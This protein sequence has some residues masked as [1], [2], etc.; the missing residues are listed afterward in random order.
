MSAWSGVIE[1]GLDQFAIGKHLPAAEIEQRGRGHR[2]EDRPRHVDPTHP[3]PRQDFL[4]A[5]EVAAA[6]VGA[7]LVLLP[8]EQR[9]IR[10]PPKAS[11]VWASMFCRVARM[12]RI[13]GRM[14]PI[15]M[16]CVIHTIGSSTSEPNSS[17]QSTN[18]STAK[19][20]SSWMPTREGPVSPGSRP[21]S[22]PPAEPY[23]HR[24]LN[25]QPDLAY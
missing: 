17:R 7:R 10:I 24:H 18:A 22:R 1:M 3:P 19:L 9:T 12:S 4:P 23:Q 6:R 13:R 5:H 8:R 21:S 15:H 20:P 2:D 25:S 14:R 16:R 11:V